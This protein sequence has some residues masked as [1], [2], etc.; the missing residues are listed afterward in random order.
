VPTG[1]MKV[2]I[3]GASGFLGT[4]LSSHLQAQGHDV[5][6]LVRRPAKAGESQWDP[7][8]G[9]VDVDLLGT[10]DVVANLA[11][12]PLV[13]I[14][15]SKKYQRTMRE[16]RIG[17]TRTLAEG[18]AKSGSTPTFLAQNGIAGYG[19]RGSDVVTEA[20]PAGAETFM[21]RLTVDW[22]AATAP[23]A[24]AGARV[25]ELRTAVVLDKRGSALK[26]MRLPFLLGVGGSIGNGRQYFSTIS[27]RDWVGA[28]TFLAEADD[29]EGPYNLTGPEPVTNAEFTKALASAL[30]RPAF[31]RVPAFAIRA[32]LGPVSTELLGSVRLKP[33]RLLEAGFTFQD[34]TVPEQLEAALS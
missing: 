7:P 16:S 5:T 3:A 26:A 4:A 22:R 21:G 30:H 28:A 8:S 34:P 14:T 18:I 11:G 9:T 31:L 33:A 25:V 2:V 32:A 24:D 13:G 1:P 19:D 15:R 10:A 23:A 20:D 29:A 27:L 12:S 17:T 6:R